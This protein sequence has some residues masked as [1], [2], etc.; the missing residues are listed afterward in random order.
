MNKPLFLKKPS[1]KASGA[2]GQEKLITGIDFIPPNN[3]RLAIKVPFQKDHELKAHLSASGLS[4]QQVPASFSWTKTDDVKKYRGIPSY[5]SSW[6]QS[7]P[8]QSTCGS[9]W[10]VSSASVLT[11]RYSIA[12]LKKFPALSAVAAASCATHDIGA[13]SCAGGFPSDCGCMFEQVG[14]PADSCWP[15]STFCAPNPN[16]TCSNTGQYSCCGQGGGGNN[17]KLK[18]G[19]N[20][21][22]QGDAVE[23]TDF[24]SRVSTDCGNN[25]GNT[26]VCQ[27]PGGDATRYKALKG[28]TV[29]LAAGSLSDIIRRIKANIFSAGP[30]VGCFNVFSDFMIPTSISGWGWKA[31]GGIYCHTDPSP[32]IDDPW[33]TSFY[34]NKDSAQYADAKEALGR[35]GVDLGSSLEEFKSNL[36]SN[37]SS[38]PGGHAVAIV[39]YGT[40]D[41]GKYGQLPYWIVRNSWGT[42]W[43]GDDKGFFRTAFRDDSKGINVDGGMESSSVGGGCT[44]FLV[45]STSVSAVNG[46]RL[47]F[48]PMKAINDKTKQFLIAA[49][50][51]AVVLI[52][53]Y[54]FMKYKKRQSVVFE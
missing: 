20:P 10:A 46:A 6:L 7:P 44:S 41:S 13:D 26:S 33:V 47:L 9:C 42:V 48:H 3:C 52:G 43:N 2:G 40:G 54:L 5:S 19:L 17:A 18:S 16:V 29:S 32:Y 12:M 14:I 11:D 15:Y 28:S 39:G 51:G 21:E 23:C 22:D 8:D 27:K 36:Q 50:V 37:F 1:M 38:P 24:Q 53:L 35:F 30:V 34:Q 25:P 4:E 49:A 31:T 45:P